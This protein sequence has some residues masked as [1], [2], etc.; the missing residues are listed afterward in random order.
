MKYSYNIKNL[1]C[2]NCAKKLE[3]RLN[4]DK[5]I[6][7]AI[8]N[9]STSKVI[10]ETDLHSPFDYVKNVVKTTE[11][12]VIISEN[13]TKENKI[14]PFIKLLIGG[15]IGLAGCMIDIPYHLDLVLVIIG[16]GI[17]VYKTLIT[18]VKQLIKGSVNENLLVTLSTIGAF[19][20]GE[21][22]EGIMVIFLYELG[23][24]LE[25][26]AV[27]KSRKS[28]AELMNIKEDNSNLKENDV[29][30]KVPTSIVKV[31]D[32][33]VVKE[34][35]KVPLDGVVITGEANLDTS[36]L[37]G[38]SSFS[39][40][41]PGDK[42]LSG[43]IN[44]QGLLEIKVTSLYKDSIVNKI[45]KLVETATEKKSKTETIVS[46][47]S[48]KYTIGVL[49][50]ATLVA[51]SMP[52]F[53]TITYL[54]SVYKGLTILVISC[55]C[56]IAIS[57]PLSYFSGIGRA[58]K[59]GILIK[60]SNYLDSIKNIKE[61]VFDKT[62][63]ITTGEFYISKINIYNNKYTEE[64]LLEIFAKGETLSNHPIAQSILKKYGKEVSSKG[65]KDYKEIIGKGIT[66]EYKNKKI[67]IGSAK[68]CDSKE[69]NKYI[70][71]KID[72]EIVSSLEIKDEIK[73]NTKDV[74]NKLQSM[75]IKIHIFTGDSKEKALEIGD[76]LNV[77]NISYEMLPNDKYNK[78]EQILK[79]KKQ[80]TIVSFVGDG[81]NDAPVI[82]L[83]DIG[84]AMG[85]L[86]TDSTIE[87]SDV[88]IMNDN[89]EKIIEAIN[90]SKKTGNIIRQNLI[91]AI[92]VK[93]TVLILS[94]LGLSTMWE[95]VFADVG[96]TVLC[97]L[98]TL[99][100][101]NR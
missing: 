76:T 45:L 44:K 88:V 86:G 98:N 66:F 87:A 30:K 33:I 53:T 36:T 54:E 55:P 74:L 73:N 31:G 70:Y 56:A 48:S 85:V 78:L 59:E 65:I 72:N 64:E 92:T 43:T 13:E 41:K 12:Q 101:I 35:E 11:P 61:I 94:L 67:K 100:L 32:V 10:I 29:I 80:N 17:L 27:D 39:F 50:I 1:T 6:K 49:I 22:T 28:V 19:I 77:K 23:K 2:A 38:E 58:S 83:S 40:V 46:K 96:V 51:I 93:S 15:L 21:I 99:R 95:A 75:N 69:D 9:Y 5:N 68:F 18:A 63:T 37:T 82:A 60:G 25:S 8:I 24:I 34:G 71:L 62:G 26:L 14:Y 20:L 47:Y 57:V 89:L 52:L 7:K 97:I 84:I 79:N 91:F 90:I 3:D 42:I 16:Y 81:I 4:K